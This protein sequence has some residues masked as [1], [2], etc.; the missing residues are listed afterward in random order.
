LDGAFKVDKQQMNEKGVLL[1][2][3]LYRSGATANAVTLAI[4]GAGV[5]RVYFLA[6]T[7]TRSKT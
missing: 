6:A 2:D 3:D 5:S 7:R 1:I 4:I